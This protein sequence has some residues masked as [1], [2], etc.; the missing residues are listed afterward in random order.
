MSRA[1]EAGDVLSWS[2]RPVA[3]RPGRG[4]AALCMVAVVAGATFLLAGPILGA[5]AL[6]LLGG[7]IAPYFVTARYELSPETVAVESPFQRVRRPWSD[8]RRVYVGRDGVSLS[9][10]R[11]YH[12][13]EP[14][15]SIML[16][17][18]EH[19]EEV[20]AWVRRFGPESPGE[21]G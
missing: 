7:S 6:L 18:G 1:P 13:L 9:P 16:R 4:V 8:I 11:R 10:F 5:L 21:V 14:Y 19:R 3:I 2:V 20:L 12:V 17:Y 15:R